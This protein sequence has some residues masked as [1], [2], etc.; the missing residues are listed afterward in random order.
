MFFFPYLALLGLTNALF[1]DQRIVLLQPIGI[2]HQSLV[3][4][5][6]PGLNDMSTLPVQSLRGNPAIL[7]AVQGNHAGAVEPISL[8]IDPYV[9]PVIPGF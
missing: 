6:A 9:I 7:T 1:L 3:I 8:R 4:G 5:L 2:L